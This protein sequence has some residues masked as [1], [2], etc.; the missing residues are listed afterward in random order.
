MKKSLLFLLVCLWLGSLPAVAG[1]SVLQPEQDPFAGRHFLHPLECIDL[2]FDG[3]IVLL[4]GAKAEVKCEGATV[5]VATG[6]KVSN[7]VGSKRTQGTLNVYFEKQNLPK[8]KEYLLVVAPGSIAKETD[9]TVV[10]TVI[11]VPFYVPATLGQAR[12]DTPDVISTAMNIWVYWKYETDPVGEPEFILYRNGQEIRK[13]PAH[14]GWDWDLGQAYADFGEEVNFEYG[15]DFRLVLPAGCVKSCYRDDIVN[16]EVVIDFRGGYTEP[17]KPLKYE[18]TTLYDPSLDV[19]DIVSFL[20]DRPVRVAEGAKMQLW[21]TDGDVLVK[22]V[23]AY[24]DDSVVN[25]W[26]VSADFGGFKMLP[27]KGYTFVMPEET[28]IAENGDPVVNPRNTVNITGKSGINGVMVDETGNGSPIY[29]L[30][31]RKV[32]APVKGGIYITDGKKIVIR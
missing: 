11:E 3:G 15:V 7:Y 6:F 18:W 1:S 22:E 31:G 16:E 12:S 9:N 28:V 29:D 20:Y 30:T 23:D 32:T 14:V 13:L 19:L 25:W 5:A 10:N 8:G 26:I 24:I 2:T 27:G 4:D 17:V 21:E